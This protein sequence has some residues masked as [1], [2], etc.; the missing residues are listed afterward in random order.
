MKYLFIKSCTDPLLW[1]VEKIGQCVPFLYEDEE[2]YWSREPAGYKN[3]V[4]KKDAQIVETQLS[5][6]KK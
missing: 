5:L 6:V 1:Y 3:I 4:L 2:Y